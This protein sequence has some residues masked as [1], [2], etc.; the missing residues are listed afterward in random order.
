MKPQDEVALL[1]RAIALAESG[2]SELAD[3]MGT[4]PVSQYV[5]AERFAQEMQNIFRRQPAA[6]AHVSELSEANAYLTV[7]SPHGSLLLTRDA[8]GHIQVFHNVCRHRGTQL[9]NEQ[10]GCA[11]R[12][13]CPYHAWT[14]ANN[15][16]LVGVPHAETGFPELRREDFGLVSLPSVL[17]YG[18]V[19]VGVEEKDFDAYLSGLAPDLAWLGLDDLRVYATEQRAWRANWKLIAEGGL[20]A[21][22]FRKAHG[23]TIAPF[24]YDNLNL[25]DRFGDHFRNVLPRRSLEKLKDQDESAWSLRHNSHMTYS[26]FPMTLFLVQSDHIVWIQARPIA[27]DQ[28]DI[29]MTTLVPAQGED[30]KKP[31]SH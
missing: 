8:D 27:P 10:S 5:D 20:E 3:R 12:F 31:E 22:H 28:T 24:F 2:G 6:V 23:K 29:R 25:W 19:W 13:S 7:D 11:K 18:L 9:V 26:L 17:R 15:G 14:Y 4:S 16:E 1:K 21:Y 30:A